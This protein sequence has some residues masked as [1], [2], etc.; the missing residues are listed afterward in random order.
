MSVNVCY[1]LD[2][3]SNSSCSHSFSLD[4]TELLAHRNSQ[5]LVHQQLGYLPRHLATSV[6]KRFYVSSVKTRDS[7]EPYDGLERSQNYHKQDY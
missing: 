7:V 6:T 2:N 1:S 5:R 3:S 4:S